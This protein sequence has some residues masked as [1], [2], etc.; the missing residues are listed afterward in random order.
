M[1]LMDPIAIFDFWLIMYVFLYL[2][3]LVNTLSQIYQV[4]DNT[5]D[6]PIDRIVLDNAGEK[7][8]SHFR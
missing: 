4:N 6:V 7:G 2:L 1:S 3:N 8:Q 5:V